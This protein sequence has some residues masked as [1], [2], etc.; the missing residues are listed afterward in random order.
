M[1][2]YIAIPSYR[3]HEV[4]KER[5]LT[6][7]DRLGIPKERIKVFVADEQDEKQYKK[8][9]SDVE[10][11]RGVPG[12]IN[13]RRFYNTHFDAGTKLLNVDDDLYDLRFVNT[14]G[15][16]VQY[17]K[18][19]DRVI[20]YAFKTCEQTGARLWGI[21]ANDNGFYMN[22]H[23]SSGL[24][25]ICGIFHGSF[26]GDP[27]L[28]GK[29]HP[30]QSSG[31]D[32]ELTLRSFKRYGVVIRLD[33]LCPKTKYF[34]PGGMQEELGGSTEARAENHH[35]ELAN[36]AKRHAGFASLYKK[37]GG[38]VNIKLKVVPSQKFSVSKSLL[39][40]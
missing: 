6:T 34:A 35:K 23:T 31:E 20:E 22:R 1:D 25:Y 21:S 17:E 18:P 15:K 13:Q 30:L 11:I 9:I 40:E 38:V 39:P 24:R 7:L 4:C 8:I 14:A 27:A 3:R 26:A 28:C 10:I 5:T 32:F 12:L 19:L 2:Y 16:V 36:I 33:W 29:D 37:K